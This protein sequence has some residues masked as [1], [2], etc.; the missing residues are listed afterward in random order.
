[1]SSWQGHYLKKSQLSSAEVQKNWGSIVN[2]PH[3]RHWMSYFMNAPWK[4][5]PTAIPPKLKNSKIRLNYFFC[6]C[7][8]FPWLPQVLKLHHA[9]SSII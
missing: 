1:M 9:H 5:S 4:W 2:N 6:C 7:L 8:S 3:C